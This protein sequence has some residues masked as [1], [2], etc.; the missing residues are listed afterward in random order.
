[1]SD[2]TILRQ[3]AAHLRSGDEPGAERLLPTI[4]RRRRER[5]RAC[6][7]APIYRA[8]RFDALAELAEAEDA[9]SSRRAS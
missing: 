2:A 6:W 8:R 3:I 7:M 9:Q 1:M 5:A 4:T